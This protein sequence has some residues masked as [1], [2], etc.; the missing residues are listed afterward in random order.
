MSFFG[1]GTDYREYYEQYGGCA[2]SATFDKYCYVTVRKLPPFFEFSNQFTYSKI[3]RVNDVSEFEHPLVRE[4]MKYL[5]ADK[6]QIAYDADLPARS[7]IGS[8]SS[9]AVGFLSA[10]HELRGEKLSKEQIAREAVYVERVL[11]KESGGVQDQYAAAYGGINRFDFTKDGVKV[12]KLGIQAE[13][14]SELEK[15][16]LLMFTGFTHFSSE[17]AG[18]QTR[19][20]NKRLPQLGELKDIADLGEKELT[21]EGDLSGFGRLLHES[22]KIKRSLSDK[23]ANDSISFIYNTAMRAGAWGGKLLGAGGGGFM[24]F[25]CPPECREKIKACFPEL[26]T[27]PFTFEDAGTGILYSHGD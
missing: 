23:I 20:I 15:S 9:F 25:A 22:W 7:G 26:K 24:L 5:G 2:I 18:D 21:G 6:L 8:S 1:G 27:V 13:R 17:I 14:K 19:N 10:L 4:A 11:C 3:E 16:L 12:K